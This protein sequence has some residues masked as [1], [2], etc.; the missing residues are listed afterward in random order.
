MI[1]QLYRGPLKFVEL[2]D[3]M[4]EFHKSCFT[5]P[6]GIRTQSCLISAVYT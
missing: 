3:Q 6:P 4:A 1:G 5:T 2:L